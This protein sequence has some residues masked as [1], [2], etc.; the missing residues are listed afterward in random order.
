MSRPRESTRT[1]VQ[2]HKR[3]SRLKK[4]PDGLSAQTSHTF[5]C[6]DLPNSS[7]DTSTSRAYL[8][9]SGQ[10]KIAIASA[11]CAW[12]MAS[13]P[14]PKGTKGYVLNDTHEYLNKN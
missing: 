5:S 10:A 14:H 6:R 11:S 9:L 13:Q 3:F 4:I 8:P 12:G 7:M 2:N 1:G